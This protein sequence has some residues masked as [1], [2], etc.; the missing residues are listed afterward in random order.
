MSTNKFWR[1][2]SYLVGD[3]IDKGTFSSI[4]LAYHNTTL[5]PYALKVISKEKVRKLNQC[6]QQANQKE[7]HDFNTNQ[8]GKAMTDSIFFAETVISP[9]L[10]H[11]NLVKTVEC[12]ETNKAFFQFMDLCTDGNL[13]D[14][15]C[16]N[17]QK[18]NFSQRIKYLT[19]I[20]DAIEYLHENF[21]CHRDIKLENILIHKGS[22]KLCD[23]GFCALCT[24][25]E[26]HQAVS[27][28]CGTV[29]YVAPEVL[30]QESYDGR[31]AD[32]WSLGIL[33][34]KLFLDDP[35]E[36]EK[37]ISY[38][39][40]D[41]QKVPN[42][43]S[44]LIKRIVIIDPSKRLTISQL[45][46]KFNSIFNSNNSVAESN[47]NPKM[48]ID[49][50]TNSKK[51][52]RS[53]SMNQIYPIPNWENNVVKIFEN[54]QNEKYDEKLISRL[55]EVF[56]K[57]RSKIIDE[58]SNNN[59]SGIINQTKILAKLIMDYQDSLKMKFNHLRHITRRISNSTEYISQN[60][61]FSNLINEPKNNK[62]YVTEF[63]DKNVCQIFKALKKIFFKYNF[64][65]SSKPNSS[66][67]ILILNTDKKDVKLEMNC[68]NGIND[69]SCKMTLYAPYQYEKETKKVIN[70]IKATC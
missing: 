40:F 3:V 35:D 13:L 41:Y 39:N 21:I 66:S 12:V 58:L 57:P 34:Y 61:N 28:K 38:K 50:K 18:V 52:Q 60:N 31:A 9:L 14:V 70:E 22:A 53:W 42:E 36:I 25:T 26:S 51:I 23:F 49:K 29:Q 10:L 68:L 47:S 54:N 69:N 17:D 4:R 45:K 33:M 1:I 32:M 67:T 8:S 48:M 6:P 2:F 37:T 64:C 7:N 27:G 16:D 19:Q 43:I 5:K 30:K 62:M 55:C 11:K 56:D 59:S 24:G 63:K 46:Q 15:L 20:I 65:I 44:E